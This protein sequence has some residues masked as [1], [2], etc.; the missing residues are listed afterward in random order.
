[1]TQQVDDT[2]RPFYSLQRLQ[3]ED[4]GTKATPRRSPPAT[5]DRDAADLEIRAPTLSLSRRL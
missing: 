5:C 1:M 4:V 2:Q 3:A